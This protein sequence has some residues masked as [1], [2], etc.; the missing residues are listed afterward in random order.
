MQQLKG[1]HIWKL[2][3]KNERQKERERERKGKNNE[4]FDVNKNCICI[5][6]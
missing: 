2:H 6:S 4:L 3:L 1:F 5:V